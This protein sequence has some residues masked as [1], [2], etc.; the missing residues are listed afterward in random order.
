M[1]SSPCPR[2]AGSI[3]GFGI[4]GLGTEG[5]GT[6][7]FSIQGLCTPGFSIQGLG[8]P[9][10]SIQG[11]GALSLSTP[12]LSMQGLCT[13]NLSTQ[14]LGTSGLAT[15][16]LRTQGLGTPSLGTWSRSLCHPVRIVCQKRFFF[17]V[18]TRVSVKGKGLVGIFLLGFKV[19]VRSQ[20]YPPHIP[21]K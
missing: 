2:T 15:T 5:L 3:Q 18:I 6:P 14:S 9:G 12:G 13:L 4:P 16:G 8:T 11:I 7:G 20:T 21:I 17:N 10:F 1:T 19:L